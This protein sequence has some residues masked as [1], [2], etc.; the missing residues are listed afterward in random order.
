MDRFFH[1]AQE[2]E[3]VEGEGEAQDCETCR[4]GLMG[5]KVVRVGEEKEG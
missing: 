2:V 1:E 4:L 5:V 3:E